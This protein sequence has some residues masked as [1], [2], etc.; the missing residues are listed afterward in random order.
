MGGGSGTE[1][2]SWERYNP[3]QQ[4]GFQELWSQGSNLM[5]QQGQNQGLQ[6]QLGGLFNTGQ[7]LQANLQNNPYMQGGYQPSQA[8]DQGM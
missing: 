1:Q 6:N 8:Y 4:A 7:G 2:R 3:A 5:N